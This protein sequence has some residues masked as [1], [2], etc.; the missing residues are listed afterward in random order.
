MEDRK[1][2]YQTAFAEEESSDVSSWLRGNHG[3]DDEISE[4]DNSL[5]EEAVL[6]ET[7]HIDLACSREFGYSKLYEVEHGL[8]GNPGTKM[9]FPK[10]ALYFER[11]EELQDLNIF[12]YECL[13]QTVKKKTEKEDGTN[14]SSMDDHNAPDSLLQ[15]NTNGRGRPS[16]LRFEYNT[17]IEIQRLFQQQLAAKYSLP[18]LIGNAPP[19]RPGSRPLLMSG[20]SGENWEKRVDS[21]QRQADIFAMYFL[22][23]LRPTGRNFGDYRFTMEALRSWIADCSVSKEWLKRTRLAVF[24][25]RLN[26]MSIS[27]TNKKLITAYRGRCRTIWT[28]EERY[29]NRKFFASQRAQRAEDLFQSGLAALEYN[30]EHYDLGDDMNKRMKVQENDLSQLQTALEGLLLPSNSHT[31]RYYNL[32]LRN[33]AM[34]ASPQPSNLNLRNN[35]MCFSSTFPFLTFHA[36]QFFLRRTTSS[37]DAANAS[38][39]NLVGPKRAKE[40]SLRLD[41][42]AMEAC[43]FDDNNVEPKVPFTPL[44]D[45]KLNDVTQTKVCTSADPTNSKTYRLEPDQK[46]V[47]DE[48]VQ[49]MVVRGGG[50]EETKPML[51]VGP[52]GTGKTHLIFAILDAAKSKGKKFICTSFNAITATAIGGDT[53]SGGFCWRPDPHLQRPS[54]FESHELIQFLQNHGFSDEHPAGD[55][56]EVVVG[57]IVEE[58]S[59]FSP[60]MICLLDI[61]L[62]QVTQIKKPFGGLILL[63]MG[64]FGQLGP[65]DACAIPSAVVHVYE[66]LTSKD[67]SKAIREE[68]AKQNKI[69]NKKKKDKISKPRSRA[70]PLLPSVTDN[71][72][73]RYSEGHP[74]RKGVELLTSAKLFSLTSQK[75]AQ[76]P[77]HRKNVESM[78]RGERYSFQMFNDYKQLKEADMQQDGD[79]CDA[80][81]LCS[82]NRERHTINGLI[83]PI[84]AKARESCVVRWPANLKEF[85]DQK[86]SDEYITDIMYSDPIF[87]EC[88]VAGTDGYLTDNICKG[89][90]IV[91]GTH[92]KNHSLSFDSIENE[93][94][95]ERLVAE[96]P[97]GG[98]VS[99]PPRLRPV[100]VNVEL[101]DP[102]EETKE[103]WRQ[104][105]RS[106]FPGRI[107]IPLPCERKFGADSKPIIVP[108]ASNGDYRC[109]RVRVTNYFPVEPGFA[110]TVYKAQGRTIPK[111]ILAISERKAVGCGMSYRAIYVAFSRVKA[112]DD[113]RFLLFDDGGSRRSLT[114]LT[115]LKADASNL[116][117]IEGF[118]KEGGAFDF[119][120]VLDKHAELTGK[121][122]Q[123]CSFPL[124]GNKRK[125]II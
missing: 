23:L 65:V 46:L 22:V 27:N 84:R 80:P 30:K 44:E 85:W 63:M 62:Q 86:P 43:K 116:A 90:R 3:D 66:F 1:D 118:S 72:E 32:N 24:N 45:G 79:F 119:Q 112:R 55:F 25:N 91:N 13:V 33:I 76:D 92:V 107:V 93:A 96:T 42:S 31:D 39:G 99:L 48:V 123:P 64:D 18:F 111:V 8:D 114:Y 4:S 125:Y 95:F 47:F 12:E 28:D 122:S 87:W 36:P 89:L 59:T 100:T 60:E 67:K 21:W 51:V 40:L 7:D 57:I 56:N 106:L 14:D 53:F 120:K 75:R 58:I 74:F 17:N 70:K 16:S 117:F 88:F 69:R 61:R 98:V 41:A 109:S 105:N 113:I 121:P 73:H 52:A 2:N 38:G 101:I 20:E 104:Q 115:H 9:A 29:T 68:I 34:F 54:P 6:H 35:A 83:A 97:V 81:V 5:Q 78:Y 124:A 10:V 102:S 103:I 15:P 77:L 19:R 26:G 11:G 94:E 82:T 110:I 108:G 37:L 49:L 71:F 50:H